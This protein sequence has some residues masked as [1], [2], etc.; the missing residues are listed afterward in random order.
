MSVCVYASVKSIVMLRNC[1]IAARRR[2]DKKFNK[3]DL[4]DYGH[5]HI[6]QSGLT[7]KHGAIG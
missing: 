1:K 3:I 5:V 2:F 7:A 4:I 6:A